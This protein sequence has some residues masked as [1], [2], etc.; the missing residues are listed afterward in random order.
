M[1]RI[2]KWSSKEFLQNIS[3]DICPSE[4]TPHLMDYLSF[5]APAASYIFL[6]PLKPRDHCIKY[7][8]TFNTK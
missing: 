1:V 4:S 5:S 7:T 8:T 6:I 2:A 3:R